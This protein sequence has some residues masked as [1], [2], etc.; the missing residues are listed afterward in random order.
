MLRH[1]LGDRESYWILRKDSVRKLETP[2]DFVRFPNPV[3]A[4][5]VR[6]KL[7]QASYNMELRE[8]IVVR[9]YTDNCD[10]WSKSY[11]TC[12]LRG[13]RQAPELGEKLTIVAL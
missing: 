5:T 2:Q 3:R 13:L 7:L 6:L 10:L 12:A 11:G 9:R 8:G 4:F 1:H